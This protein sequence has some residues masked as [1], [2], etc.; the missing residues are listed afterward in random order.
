MDAA[1]RSMVRQR[2]GNCCEYCGLL[3]G[4]MSAAV[5]HVDHS[6]FLSM[7]CPALRALPWKSTDDVRES[8]DMQDFPRMHKPNVLLRQG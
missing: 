4:Q 5:F 8:A 6:T 1:T 7:A 3:Q 2:A